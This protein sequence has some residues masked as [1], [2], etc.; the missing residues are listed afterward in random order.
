MKHCKDL[1]FMVQY[2]YYFTYSA[3]QKKYKDL[4]YEVM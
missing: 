3:T 2:Y 4:T 1:F